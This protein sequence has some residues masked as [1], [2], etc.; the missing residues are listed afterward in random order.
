MQD[1]LAAVAQP[2]LGTQSS[3]GEEGTAHPLPDRLYTAD[4]LAEI[5]AQ[6]DT[7]HYEL[8][9]GKLTMMS[10][11]GGTHGIIASRLNAALQ[12]YADEHESGVAF[13]A[14]TGYRVNRDPD[15]VLAPDASFLTTARIPEDGITQGYIAAA[16]DLVV[17]V[18]SPSDTVTRVQQKVQSWFGY[19]TQLVWVVEPATQT[20]TVYR[21]DGSARVLQRQ[22]TLD[23]E[24]VLPG[25]SYPLARLFR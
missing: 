10:P 7:H 18:V 6:D 17:E 8:L 23:G 21:P 4:E 16:P 13:A 22:D 11:A 2:E 3:P 19:G 20:V 25:F 15:T 9:K 14:E 1:K 24:A 5:S 12:N